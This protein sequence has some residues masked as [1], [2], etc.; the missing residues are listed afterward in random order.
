MV[1]TKSFFL[2]TAD[3]DYKVNFAP[4]FKNPRTY[5][6]VNPSETTASWMKKAVAQGYDALLQAHYKDYASLFNRVSLTLN[7]G[8]KTQDIP[9]PQRLINY[10]KGQE[11][12]T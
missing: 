9:T 4:D 12:I 3:T 7:D 11:D 8:Q 5:V 10:R 1:L 6:G 2:I